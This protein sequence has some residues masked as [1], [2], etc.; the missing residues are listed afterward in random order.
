MKENQLLK[1]RKKNT[2]RRL[3]TGENNSSI[4]NIPAS[5]QVRASGHDNRAVKMVLLDNQ[6]IQKVG[7][8]KGALFK[9]HV[10]IGMSRTNCKVDPASVKTV[11]HRRK[12]GKLRNILVP[13]MLLV[14][15]FV[16]LFFILF[17]LFISSCDVCIW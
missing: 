4:P 12:T 11:K 15:V 2:K 14:C 9:R 5:N 10:N 6:N 1:D 17:L 7:T 3:S 8:G 13:I 16:L